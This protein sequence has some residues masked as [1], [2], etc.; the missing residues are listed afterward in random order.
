MEYAR[1]KLN[2]YRCLDGLDLELR[3]LNVL[4]GPNGSG[5]T[6]LLDAFDLLRLGV[7]KQFRTSLSDRGGIS[8]LLTRTDGATAKAI[9]IVLESAVAKEK[10]PLRYQLRVAPQG[11]GYVIATELLSQLQK[12]GATTPFMFIDAKPGHV[13][14]HKKGNGLVAPT[15]D[16]QESE[17]ALAQV[18]NLYQEPEEFRARLAACR[19]YGHPDVGPRSPIRTA[20]QL[21][22]IPLVPAVDGGDLVAV[23]YNLQAHEKAN[24]RL[25]EAIEAG[26]T[27]F[28]GLAF[29]VVAAGRVTA[30][31]KTK[32]GARFELHELSEGTLRFLWLA[33]LLLSPTKPP[34]IFIDE[35]EISLHP[36]LIKVLA[37]MLREAASASQVFVATHSDRLLR[38]LEPGDLVLF[39]KEDGIARARRGDDPALDVQK[40]L[41]EYTLDQVWLMGELGARP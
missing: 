30:V 29:P 5:K 24:V 12:P 37:G 14:Y 4:I 15:W 28:D 32:S 27:D 1:L 8:A 36:E 17:L 39:D 3:G 20:Q 18:P 40:W 6:S 19:V 31:W 33:A 22:P 38:W 26:F 23:L 41:S 7:Q 25:L 9:E 16:Y 21:D 34:A 35:P 2:G 11:V 13:R 10:K